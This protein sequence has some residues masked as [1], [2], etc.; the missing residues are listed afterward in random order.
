MSSREKY[1]MKV[2]ITNDD[3]ISAPGLSALYWE[4]S[5]NH[6]VFLVAPDRERS[7]IGHGITLNQPLRVEA[8]NHNGLKGYAINGTPADCVKL[9]VLSLMSE[10]PDI[11]VS[12]INPGANLA[13][14][15]N[16]SGTLGAAREAAIYGIPAIAT[17]IMGKQGHDFKYSAEF[18]LEI[19]EKAVKNG[20]PKGTLLNINFPNIPRDKILGKKIT[21]QSSMVP[22]ET[23][24]VRTDPRGKK[25][26]WYGVELSSDAQ[27]LDLD[28]PAVN[29]GYISISPIQC[30]VT[31]YDFLE[32]LNQ[33]DLDT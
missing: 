20:L 8:A 2:M 7:A 11:V 19:A 1:T 33:W 29:S 5:Q 6:E 3:G 10:K 27:G 13:R 23:I 18:T 9:A 26:H 16:Y 31:D 14:N 28:E 12:G 22:K 21:K 32:T 4:F 25:Y 24:E 17:S 15:I 30:D